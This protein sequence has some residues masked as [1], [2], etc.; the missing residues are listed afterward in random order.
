MVTFLT[1]Y[2]FSF[3]FFFSLQETMKWSQRFWFFV[4]CFNSVFAYHFNYM[5]RDYNSGFNYGHIEETDGQS[6]EGV[7]YCE[8]HT[9]SRK[10]RVK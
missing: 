6:I 7:H 3:Y 5:V 1:R 9:L 8:G 2:Y 10:G 4:S